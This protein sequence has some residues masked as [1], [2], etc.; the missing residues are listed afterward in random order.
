M[1]T[2]P[3]TPHTNT[4]SQHRHIIIY[5]YY[6]I[7]EMPKT[8]TCTNIHTLHCTPNRAWIN[9]ACISILVEEWG[10]NE[11]HFSSCKTWVR[12]SIHYI[13]W[14]SLYTCMTNLML[15]TCNLD[16]THVCMCVF[17]TW[18]GYKTNVLRDHNATCCPVVLFLSHVERVG[19]CHFLF[20]WNISLL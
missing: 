12:V 3:P 4:N 7:I 14:H 6:R 15:P 2:H 16:A 11:A 19:T 10:W 5:M 18:L 8:H 1:H 13:W 17:V 9:S 20:S